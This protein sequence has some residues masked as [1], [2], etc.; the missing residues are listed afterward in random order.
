MHNPNAVVFARNGATV[1]KYLKKLIG[2]RIRITTT[3]GYQ[4]ET[5]VS[6]VG[7]YKLYYYDKAL[8]DFDSMNMLQFEAVEDLGLRDSYIVLDKKGAHSN[9]RMLSQYSVLAQCKNMREARRYLPVSNLKNRNRIVILTPA[10]EHVTLESILLKNK[11][12][13]TRLRNYVL[14]HLSDRNRRKYT[15]TN[16]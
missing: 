9:N 16:K 13:D 8:N 11:Y 2:R 14:D 3:T 5:F 15:N 12:A 4:F 1:H 6:D 7:K 10:G